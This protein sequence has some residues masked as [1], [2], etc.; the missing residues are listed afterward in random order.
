MHQVSKP[1]AS[2][3]LFLRGPV[4]SKVR[5]TRN[6]VTCRPPRKSFLRQKGAANVVV[7]DGMSM[8]CSDVTNVPSGSY[9]TCG[10]EDKEQ[11]AP[12]ELGQ[13]CWLLLSDFY[14]S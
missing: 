12:S 2:L 1:V 5:A 11:V 14:V 3:G 8:H 10:R 9:H 4:A 6:L 7:V 13:R